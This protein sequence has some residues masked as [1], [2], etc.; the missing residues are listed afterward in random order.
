M[1]GCHDCSGQVTRGNLDAHMSSPMRLFTII[2]SQH[3]RNEILSDQHKRFDV[4][5]ELAALVTPCINRTQADIDSMFTQSV[6]ALLEE[7]ISFV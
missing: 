1:N 4:M 5:E 7:P 2:S 6:L 3:H